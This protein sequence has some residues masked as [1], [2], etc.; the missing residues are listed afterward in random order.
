VGANKS[1]RDGIFGKKHAFLE[2]GADLEIEM[3]D[4]RRDGVSIEN[5]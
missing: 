5:V 4:L 1:I 2:R 3:G